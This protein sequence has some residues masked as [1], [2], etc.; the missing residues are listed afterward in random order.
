MFKESRNVAI[1]APWS[2]YSPTNPLLQAASPVLLD[3][4]KAHILLSLLIRYDRTEANA[5][6]L[7]S[8]ELQP[9]IGAFWSHPHAKTQIL[10]LRAQIGLA[11]RLG[12]T[13]VAI[14]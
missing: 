3:E 9:N 4:K 5:G 11:R 14:K 12:P 2:T 1:L 8:Q 10:S 6:L 13:R 7:T